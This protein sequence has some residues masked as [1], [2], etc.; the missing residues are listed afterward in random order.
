MACQIYIGCKYCFSTKVPCAF[1][2]QE[3]NI[4]LIRL[5]QVSTRKLLQ[6]YKDKGLKV[7]VTLKMK[8]PLKLRTQSLYP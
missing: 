8:N 3:Q 7:T 1:L 2:R 5:K 6:H 4:F